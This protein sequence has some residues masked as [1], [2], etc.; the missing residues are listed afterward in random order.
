[1][2][3]FVHLS[4]QDPRQVAAEGSYAGFPGVPELTAA[5]PRRATDAAPRDRH[6]LTPALPAEFEAFCALHRDGYHDYARVHPAPSEA[7]RLVRD[8][9]CELALGWPDIIGA[10][11]PAARAWGRERPRVRTATTLPSTQARVPRAAV[12]RARTALLVATRR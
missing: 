6:R 5:L 10:P 4:P 2:G 3:C 8:A 7:H 12:R 11:D 1:M 9:R